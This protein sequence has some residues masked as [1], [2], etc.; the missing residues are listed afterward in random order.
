M[1]EVRAMENRRMRSCATHNRA[2]LIACG[3]IGLV[4]NNA[5][6]RVVLDRRLEVAKFLLTLNTAARNA[7]GPSSTRGNTSLMLV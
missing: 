6:D 3:V 5:P 2:P 7:V 1:A 4:G